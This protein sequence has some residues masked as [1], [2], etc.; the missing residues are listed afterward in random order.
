MYG[1]NIGLRV[2][3]I[4]V[5]LTYL[6]T[7]ENHQHNMIQKTETNPFIFMQKLSEMTVQTFYN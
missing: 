3:E 7:L 1:I 4:Y 6:M 2:N 5:I